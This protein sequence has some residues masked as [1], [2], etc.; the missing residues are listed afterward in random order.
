MVCTTGKVQQHTPNSIIIKSYHSKST[1]EVELT[2]HELSAPYLKELITSH[3]VIN[4][5][6]LH[7]LKSTPPAICDMQV[8]PFLARPVYWQPLH[9]RNVVF[10]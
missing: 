8:T 4:N 7:P 2:L 5:V 10:Y 9:M 1:T 3:V 6:L